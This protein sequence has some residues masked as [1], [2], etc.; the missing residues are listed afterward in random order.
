MVAD[1]DVEKEAKKL[2]FRVVGNAVVRPVVEGIFLKPGIEAGLFGALPMLGGPCL[3]LGDL[4]G[5][6]LVKLLLRPEASPDKGIGAVRVRDPLGEPERASVLLFR[7]VHRFE[8]RGADA[9]D[10]PEMEEFVSSDAGEKIIR[11]NRDGR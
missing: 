5:E 9:L 8:S 11:G 7:V 10:I 6:V 2:A 3:K 1:Q 4:V